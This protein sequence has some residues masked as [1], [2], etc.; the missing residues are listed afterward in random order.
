MAKIAVLSFF[1]FLLFSGAAYSQSHNVTQERF[2]LGYS[3]TAA[4]AAQDYLTTLQ[5]LNLL[6]AEEREKDC[7]ADWFKNAVS[8]NSKWEK[9]R[10][11]TPFPLLL[12]VPQD[13]HIQ[14]W[15][16]WAPVTEALGSIE[17]IARWQELARTGAIN[18][19]QG[20][21]CERIIRVLS[22]TPGESVLAHC[23]VIMAR[24]EPGAPSECKPVAIITADKTW[25]RVI[26]SYS[27]VSGRGFGRDFNMVI[28]GRRGANLLPTVLS[29]SRNAL[30]D[31]PLNLP[32]DQF[33]NSISGTAK[34][35]PSEPLSGF[36]PRLR[37]MVTVR[38]ETANGEENVSFVKLLV[39]LNLYVNPWA[40]TREQDWHAPN[41][42]QEETYLQ[43]V[44]NNLKRRMLEGCSNPQWRSERVLTCGLP[45]NASL[46]GWVW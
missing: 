40:T 38:V 27:E 5:Q 36:V 12:D 8:S 32:V 6:N 28:L 46:P 19:C 15:L 24:G 4:D 23:R 30:T 11:S 10:F 25:V 21:N 29:A 16:G 2:D 41:P 45:G 44:K 13:T 42:A 34:Y 43:A 9:C 7:R 3:V 22:S 31:R 18:N 39:S 14:P 37:E 1:L 33:G 17:A 20:P 26:T 35:R